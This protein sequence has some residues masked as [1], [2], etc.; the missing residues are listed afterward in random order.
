MTV[1]DSWPSIPLAELRGL[2]DRAAEEVAAE[3]PQ[4]IPANILEFISR[5]LTDQE[6]YDLHAWFVTTLN[7]VWADAD[8]ALLDILVARKVIVSVPVKFK[9][10]FLYAK[11]K[12]A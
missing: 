2:M 10:E 4:D 6:C 5:E 9:Q 8:Q 7:L 3:D 1:G 11:L 12:W